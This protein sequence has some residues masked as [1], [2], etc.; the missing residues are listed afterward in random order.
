MRVACPQCLE[1]VSAENINMQ[2]MMALCAHCSSLFA[3]ELPRKKP[4][5]RKVQKPAHLSVSEDDTL[6]IN[7][8]TNF[9]LDKNESFLNSAALSGVFSLI[10]VLMAGLFLEGEVPLFLPLLFVVFSLTG[11][12]SLATIA[13]NKTHISFDG[14]NLC[15]SRRPLPAFTARQ[16]LALAAVTAFY[17]E[18]SSVSQEKQYDTARFHVWAELQDGSR[19]LVVADLTEAYAWYIASRLDQFMPENAPA[20]GSRLAIESPSEEMTV[21]CES[22]RSDQISA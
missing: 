16:E 3:I 8:R 1:Q 15:R 14:R 2:R 4:K 13:F 6:R 21:C 22:E 19:R 12:Y 17:A 10:S 7:F 18:E 20:E 5:R 11:F 9:R